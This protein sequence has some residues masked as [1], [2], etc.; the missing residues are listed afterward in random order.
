M[1][2]DPKDFL[3]LSKD[4]VDDTNYDSESAFRT[5]ISRAYY[6]AFLVCRAWLENAHGFSFPPTADAHKL[7]VRRLRKRRV[8]RTL[9]PGRT[10]VASALTSLRRSGRNVADYNLLAQVQ[11]AVALSWIQIAEYAIDSLP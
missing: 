3:Q 1:P 5:S 4:L 6:S 11:K 10:A 2:F 9:R 7:V 8:L